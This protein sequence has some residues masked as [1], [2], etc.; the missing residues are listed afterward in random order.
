[1]VLSLVSSMVTVWQVCSPEAAVD[2]TT[3][4][5][6]LPVHPDCCGLGSGNTIVEPALKQPGGTLRDSDA[7]STTAGTAESEVWTS[8]NGIVP[9]ATLTVP[10]DGRFRTPSPPLPVGSKSL[11]ESDEFAFPLITVVRIRLGR[12]ADDAP[13]PWMPEENEVRI[14]SE[15]GASLQL[16]AVPDDST[17]V[18]ICVPLSATLPRRMKY[19]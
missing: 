5:V 2:S 9:P 13:K 4:V 14:P 18:V 12:S 15:G 8:T 16:D 17:T 6:P 11:Q 19:R 1:M 10:P 3:W 7:R